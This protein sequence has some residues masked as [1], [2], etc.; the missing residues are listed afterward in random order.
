MGQ[1]VLSC[2]SNTMEHITGNRILILKGQHS[3]QLKSDVGGID[4]GSV[5]SANENSS[6]KN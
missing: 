5:V 4:K 6:V 1:G 3:S 2:L